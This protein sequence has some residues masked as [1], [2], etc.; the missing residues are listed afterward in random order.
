MKTERKT[1]QT[2][3]D[4]QQGIAGARAQ[5][6]LGKDNTELVGSRVG[7]INPDNFSNEGPTAEDDMNSDERLDEEAINDDFND[8]YRVGGDTSHD[9]DDN[10]QLGSSTAR[11]S[12]E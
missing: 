8:S 4:P 6:G 3:V 5:F 10:Y 1:P 12:G 2:E 11:T 9:R 7:R